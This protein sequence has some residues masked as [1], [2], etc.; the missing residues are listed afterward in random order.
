[1]ILSSAGLHIKVHECGGDTT[2]TLF[3]LEIG[4][5]CDCEHSDDDDD[6]CCDEK[7]IIVKSDDLDKTIAKSAKINFQSIAVP[8]I[9]F[10]NSFS[11]N[12]FNSELNSFPNR[13]IISDSSPPIYLSNNVFRI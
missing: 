5:H 13:L 2:I 12:I 3:D 4:K 6:G 9:Q 10:T 11:N 8:I 7:T 1:M